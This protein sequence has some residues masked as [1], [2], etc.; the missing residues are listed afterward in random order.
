[1]TP[2]EGDFCQSPEGKAVELRWLVI[3]RDGTKFTNYG[4][5]GSRLFFWHQA[6]RMGW[7]KTGAWFTEGTSVVM[8]DQEGHV[9]ARK[10]MTAIRCPGT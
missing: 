10:T 6:G 5:A 7:V 9:L 8:T 2:D 4:L 3:N 1:M